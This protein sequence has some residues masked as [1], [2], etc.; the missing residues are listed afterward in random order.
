MDFDCFEQKI[1]QIEQKMSELNDL[2]CQFKMM[3]KY[4]IKK[5]KTDATPSD[6]ENANRMRQIYALFEKGYNSWE[7][8]EQ[9]K[10]H[11]GSVWDAF[12]FVAHFRQL[13]KT[14]VRYAR[15]YLVST[16]AKNGMTFAEI[17]KIAGCS[18]ERC[19]QIAH[20]FKN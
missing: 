11:F 7:I 6:L 20:T 13:E 17:G 12:M 16:L 9:M 5:E 1:E 14:K 10:S 2:L 18:R 4:N 19:C 3:A 15:A 8:A